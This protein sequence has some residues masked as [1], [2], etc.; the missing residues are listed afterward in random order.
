MKRQQAC[1]Y[2]NI[3][4]QP[5]TYDSLLCCNFVL[6]ETI[7]SSDQLQAIGNEED[8]SSLY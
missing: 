8:A 6:A 2:C 3:D 5:M 1:V 7:A 4:L